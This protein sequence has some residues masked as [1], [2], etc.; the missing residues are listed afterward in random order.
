M[1]TVN[2]G[3]SPERMRI[4]WKQAVRDAELHPGETVVIAF[5]PGSYPLPHL[6]AYVYE[7]SGETMVIVHEPGIF[8]Y[9]RADMRG[10]VVI[11]AVKPAA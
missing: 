6:G 8:M 5:A 10:K 9:F 4:I 2:P 11:S 7:D 3:I 1:I